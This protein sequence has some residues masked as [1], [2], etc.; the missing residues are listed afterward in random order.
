MEV[1]A[2]ARPR[3]PCCFDHPEYGDQDQAGAVVV[4]DTG[5]IDVVVSGYEP[6]ESTA[7]QLCESSGLSR[8]AM[9]ATPRRARKETQPD[10]A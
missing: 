4:G 6:G 9:Y 3:T 2:A 7:A 1:D 8:S 10:R 5:D